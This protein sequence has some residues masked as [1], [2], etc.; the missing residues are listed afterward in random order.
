MLRI[1]YRVLP[2]VV[3][4]VALPGAAWPWAINSHIY[5]A[6][7]I[8]EDILD[9]G[10]VAFER[11]I[12]NDDGTTSTEH[13]CDIAVPSH[14]ATAIQQCPLEFR[15]GSCCADLYPDMYIG[16]S[17]IHPYVPGQRWRSVDWARHVVDCAQDYGEDD[18][19]HNKA[20]AFAA[21]WLVHLGGDA[22]GHTW[23]NNYAGGAW[24]W[25]NMGIVSKHVAVESYVNSKL[26]GAADGSL[27][28]NL[29]LDMDPAFIRDTLMLHD[30]I[31]DS[32][33]SAGYMVFLI[34]YY[35][36]FQAAEDKCERKEDDWWNP[37]S[38]GIGAVEDWLEHQ[39]KEADRAMYEWAQTSTAI[40]NDLSAS[41]FYNI[42]GR[43]TD[44]TGLWTAKLCLGIPQA[45]FDVID[46]LGQPID[47]VMDPIEDEMKRLAEDIYDE[48]LRETFEDIVNPEEFM[49]A[50]YGPGVMELVDEEMHVTA[51]HADMVW[52]EFIPFYDS[53]VIGKLA[54]LDKPG[55]DQLSTAL[56]VEIPM[57][58]SGDNI[59]YDCVN[60][61]DASN[62]LALY[63]VFRLLET[64]QIEESAY[65]P[66]F[67]GEPYQAPPSAIDPAHVVVYF[68]R[69]N[70]LNVV[71]G[72]PLLDPCN[73]QRRVIGY[74][75]QEHDTGGPVHRAPIFE[76]GVATHM[77]EGLMTDF[78]PC[79]HAVEK[80]GIY[81][82][83][84]ATTGP[85]EGSTDTLEDRGLDLSIDVGATGQEAMGNV[86]LTGMPVDPATMAQFM[87]AM[88]QAIQQAGQ[89]GGP[90]MTPEQQAALQEALQQMREGLQDAEQFQAAGGVAGAMAAAQQ[91]W[92]G[93]EPLVFPTSVID[94][95][96]AHANEPFP[97]LPEGATM[98]EEARDI[99]TNCRTSVGVIEDAEGNPL[100][101]AT[102]T[103][104]EATGCAEM[105]ANTRAA[106]LRFDQYTPGKYYMGRTNE[107]GQYC[108]QAVRAGE[109]VLIASAAGHPKIEQPLSF[110]IPAGSAVILPPVRLVADEAAAEDEA[111]TGGQHP[112]SPDFTINVNPRVLTPAL[113]DEEGNV[114]AT[115]LLRAIG[116]F[117]GEVQLAVDGL[118]GGIKADFAQ[119]P[120]FVD[121]VTEVP[122]TFTGRAQKAGTVDLVITGTAGAL[123]HQTRLVLS[124]SAGEMATEPGQLT[125][126]RGGETTLR[127][128]WS[129]PDGIAPA[130]RFFLDELP[131]GI[132]VRAHTIKAHK[133]VEPLKL[134]G[135]TPTEAEAHSDSL[136][137]IVPIEPIPRPERPQLTVPILQK[138]P[139]DAPVKGILLGPEGWVDL[140]IIADADAEPGTLRIPVK[141]QIGFKVTT[142]VVELTVE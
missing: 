64:E 121:A 85:V 111:Y 126:K 105:R 93:L 59:L 48:L 42:P 38:W 49:L 119:N 82:F 56:G 53:V 30:D 13:L 55:I 120:A 141:R 12:H 51:D 4:L 139:E 101:H 40:G 44:W 110:T 88:A 127:V 99:I 22:I 72:V 106:H 58:D 61:M 43:V 86:D 103:L 122:V 1:L 68:D 138:G 36:A 35:D 96:V 34:D 18:A 129:G 74:L 84:L 21:G 23:V 109:Y 79:G 47:W 54:L 95:I 112:Y 63:P 97:D 77:T 92:Q 25:G 94:S 14:I 75:Y 24:D 102:V 52:P 10:M 2:A 116:N 133:H 83:H 8:M 9:D 107:Q 39:R 69:A 80:K 3:A 115:V 27:D 108:L 32:L 123:T 81:K 117:R 29:D 140:L 90:Q 70:P 132:K 50:A 87:E 57:N 135:L 100:Q 73:D 26:P 71:F 20:V 89:Q 134:I 67:K 33:P 45:V 98:S 114:G 11:V 7:I 28:I 65:R 130:A 15:A 125:V 5:Q 37:V 16:Q 104:V 142:E 66:L 62:Q 17:I 31:Y 19:Q 46:W 6:D 78:L 137:K 60:S 76:H 128:K 136:R 131:A 118:P 41:E 91:A 124:T 113:A